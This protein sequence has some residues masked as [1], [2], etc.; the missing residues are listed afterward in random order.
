MGPSVLMGLSV[1]G[2]TFS[3]QCVTRQPNAPRRASDCCSSRSFRAESGEGR[4]YCEPVPKNYEFEA[5]NGHE[6]RPLEHLAEWVRSR[7][8]W[9]CHADT[10]R[11][12]ELS[13][14]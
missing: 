7:G 2:V 6:M 8:D 9:L 11:A 3:P 4:S 13:Q 12:P 14:N 5:H 1:L 10:D